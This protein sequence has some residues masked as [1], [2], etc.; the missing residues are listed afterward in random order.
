MLASS[1]TK[2]AADTRTEIM[3]AAQALIL[4]QGFAGTSLDAILAR[5]GL[6]KGAFFHHFRTK[7]EL[8]HALVERFARLDEELLEATMERAERLSRD[9]AQQLLIFVGL[10]EE[11]A[12]ALADPHPGCL[13]ASY[14]YEAQLFDERIHEI[15]RGS[16]Q[17]WRGR[18]GD[19]I[20]A[21]M[22]QR[23]PRLPAD[24]DDLADM[25]T[26]V[27]EGAFVLS[28]TLKDAQAVARQF[29]Q[30]RNYLELLFT[31]A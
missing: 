18:L 4:E 2:I 15:I 11:Q 3:D 1:M 23:P 13:F 16:F 31:P 19:K 7:N 14:C 25:L 12:S 29:R 9:P 21:A 30:Y 17:L 28:K 8:A 20:R 26:V 24:A 10:L 6:T 5:V 27:A 22:A